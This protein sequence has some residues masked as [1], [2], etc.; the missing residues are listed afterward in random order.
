MTAEA[1][2][3]VTYEQHFAVERTVRLVAD[4]AAFPHGPVLKNERAGLLTMAGR[5]CLVVPCHRQSAAWLKDVAAVW[6][7]AVHTIHMAFDDRMMLR[8]L[9]FGLNI[10][11]T[12]ETSF[13]LFARVDDESGRSAGYDVPAAGTVTGFA[14]CKSGSLGASHP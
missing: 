12:T 8:Q 14:T 6:V 3:G 13:R 4:S 2:V 1:E 10:Q 11:M 9:E 5:T 7:M